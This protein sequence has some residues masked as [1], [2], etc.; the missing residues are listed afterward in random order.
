MRFY[1][2]FFG[3]HGQICD[4]LGTIL[5]WLSRICANLK[6]E[7]CIRHFFAY[8]AHILYDF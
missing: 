5:V 7:K 1:E 8:V 3:L 4:L 6:I 2:V